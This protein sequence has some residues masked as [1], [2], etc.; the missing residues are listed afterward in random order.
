VDLFRPS[1]GIVSKLPVQFFSKI[2]VYLRGLEIPED[3]MPVV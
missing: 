2:T 3:D 1:E